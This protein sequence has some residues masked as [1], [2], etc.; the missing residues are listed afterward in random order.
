M[1][2]TLTIAIAAAVLLPAAAV[3]EAAA[4]PRFRAIVDN[5]WFPLEPGTILVYEG[6]KDGQP[7]RDVFRVTS[8]GASIRVPYGSFKHAL[9]TREWTVLEPGVV[10]SKYYVRGIG[11]VFE[12]SVKGAKETSRLVSVKHA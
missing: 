6:V 1:I 7:Q 3:A 11:E 4:T 9:R 10:D 2:R 8:L 5:Q 12:G